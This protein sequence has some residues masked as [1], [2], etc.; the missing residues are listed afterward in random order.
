MLFIW[1]WGTISLQIQLDRWHQLLI[2]LVLVTHSL[3]RSRLRI[4]FNRNHS[5]N[6]LDFPYFVIIQLPKKNRVKLVHRAPNGG[7]LKI[8]PPNFSFVNLTDFFWK[9]KISYIIFISKTRLLIIL[10]IIKTLSKHG[11]IF[12]MTGQG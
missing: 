6:F 9:S 5:A 4:F 3:H 8:T 11:I 7:V 1:Q 2:L 12:I 10:V